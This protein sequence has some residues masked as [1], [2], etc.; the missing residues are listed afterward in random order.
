[1]RVMDLNDWL[2]QGRDAGFITAEFCI[3]HDSAP[4]TQEEEAEWE[5]GGDPCCF[6]V[7]LRHPGMGEL[8]GGREGWGT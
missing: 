2:R 7:R 3:T 1:M 6:V 8:R 5:D 4:I